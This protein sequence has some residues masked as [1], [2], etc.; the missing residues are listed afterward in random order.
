MKK[1]DLNKYGVQKMNAGEMCYV[2]GGNQPVASYMTDAQIQAAGNAVQTVVGFFV[3]IVQ[4]VC[5]N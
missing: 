5:K 1:L 4:I 3:G 2:D